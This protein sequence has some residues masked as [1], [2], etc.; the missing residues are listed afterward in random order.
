[1]LRPYSCPLSVVRCQ[2]SVVSGR[3]NFP[4]ASP[5][6]CSQSFCLFQFRF[7]PF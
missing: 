7:H 2:L 6:P 1:M 4:T 5:V 3:N